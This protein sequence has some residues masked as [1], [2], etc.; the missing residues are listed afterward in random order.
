M[1]KKTCEKDTI[2]VFFH[3]DKQKHSNKTW[4]KTAS[5]FV[6]MIGHDSIVPM[7]RQRRS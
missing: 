1:K 2:H 4:Q 7:N 6:F 3:P 5:E